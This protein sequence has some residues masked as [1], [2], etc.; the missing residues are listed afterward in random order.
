MAGPRPPGG[1][2]TTLFG[3]T[4]FALATAAVLATPPALTAQEIMRAA[5]VPEFGP[6]HVLRVERD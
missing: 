5:V 3:L 2:P 1:R 4:A 6:P